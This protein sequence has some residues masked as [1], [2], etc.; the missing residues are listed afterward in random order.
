MKTLLV[1][2]TGFSDMDY[3]QAVQRETV[4]TPFGGAVLYLG[5]LN[6]LETGFLARHGLEHDRLAPQVN[7]RA[8][9]WAA[10][11]LGFQAVL[12][13]SAVASLKTPIGVGDLVLPDQLVD[14]SKHREDS[15]FLRSV[16]MTHPFSR[17]LRQL[18]VDVA[19]AAGIALHDSATYLT[20]E[21]P[22]YETAAEIRLYQS[23]GMDVVG[24]TN[25][26]EAALC[27][28]LGICYATIALVTNMGAGLSDQGPDLQR[29]RQVTQENLPRFKRLALAS[30]EAALRAKPFDCES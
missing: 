19:R 23:W 14:L 16:N 15:F 17:P 3:L 5:T 20:V 9:I 1:G 29:H 24:M 12:G 4:R 21:G 28:E 13:T 27:R 2:G 11:E 7:Y 6:G 8:N 10:H 25:G 26:T 30:L 22:R 18:V